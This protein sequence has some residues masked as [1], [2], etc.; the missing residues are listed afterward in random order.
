MMNTSTYCLL[1]VDNNTET[2][3]IETH[4]PFLDTSEIQDCGIKI[5]LHVDYVREP[6]V[7]VFFKGELYNTSILISLLGISKDTSIEN[8]IIQL[9]KRHGIE[10]TL[11]VLD[12]N[13][14]FILFDYYYRY[15]ISKIY[16]VK[17]IFGRIPL[18][19]HHYRNW[20]LLDNSYKNRFDEVRLPCGTNTTTFIEKKS[21]SFCFFKDFNKIH[22]EKSQEPSI[23]S[24]CYCYLFELSS[25][26]SSEW[27]QTEKIRYYTLPTTVFLPHEQTI[28]VHMYKFMLLRCLDKILLKICPNLNQDINLNISKKLL[29]RF[30]SDDFYVQNISVGSDVVFS[31]KNSLAQFRDDMRSDM[32]RFD[33]AVRESFFDYDLGE[34]DIPGGKSIPSIK[35]VFFDKEFIAFYFSVPLEIRYYCHVDLFSVQ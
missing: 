1:N 16:V 27:K 31:A 13:F 20:I 26:I 28:D 19:L 5:K 10:Y 18:Y 25:K 15:D 32:F 2:K 4:L 33:Y 7:I 21:P 30:W 8:I 9:Y 14:I 22:T 35:Y 29:S 17:D 3:M 24:P 11:Q 34:N 6:D 12:G 23:L